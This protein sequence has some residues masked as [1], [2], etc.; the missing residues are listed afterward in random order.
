M[1]VPSLPSGYDETRHIQAGRSDCHVTVGFN[2][3]GRHIP[4]FI[5]Q[6]HYQTA[7]HPTE[8]TE[9][10]RM[11]HNEISSQGHDVYQ[12]GL[13]VDM[14]RRSSGTVHVQVSHSPLSQS[15]G[16]VIRRCDRYL[17]READYFISVYEEQ[18]PPAR[19]PRWS[20]GGRPE[21]GFMSSNPLLESMNQ[22]S[23][24]EEALAPE[25]LSELLADVEGMTAAEIEREAADIEMAPPWEGTVVDE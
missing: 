10:A 7:T 17:R 5:I 9:I 3:Q 25:E 12:E 8:W 19:P 22:E 15:R 24:T 4:R 21:D 1:T 13:H 11:D 6:L 23:S 2:W 20:D 16:A 14:H 18:Q